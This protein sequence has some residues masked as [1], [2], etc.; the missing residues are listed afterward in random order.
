MLNN[1]I[2]KSMKNRIFVFCVCIIGW[3]ILQSQPISLGLKSIENKFIEKKVIQRSFT[4][5]SKITDV[6]NEKAI[7]GISISG[8]VHF[9]DKSGFVKVVLVSKDSIEYLIFDGFKNIFDSVSFNDFCQE[10]FILD[11]ITPLEI[12]IH[13]YQA[14]MY[15][16][17]INIKS[18]TYSLEKN[19]LTNKRQELV[20][21][22]NKLKIE[23]LNDYNKKNN[24]LWIA[25]ETEISKI[26][27]QQKKAILGLNNNTYL[28]GF[29]Y[30]IGGIFEFPQAIE[31]FKE[32]NTIVDTLGFS[33]SVNKLETTTTFNSYISE[34]DWR[35]K[36]NA[37]NINSYYYDNDINENGWMTSIKNQGSLG[38]CWMFAACG[39]TEAILNI[40]YNQHID[41]DLA[42]Q[43]AISCCPDCWGSPWKG[44]NF[45]ASIGIVEEICFPYTQDR[46]TPCSSKQCST[47]LI[48]ISEVI[49]FDGSTE[50]KLKKMIVEYGPLSGT[51]C[52][53]GCHCMTL[54]GFGIVEEGDCIEINGVDTMTIPPGHIA[55]GKTY[56]IFK[57]QYG[58]EWGDNGYMNILIDYD[59]ITAYA[60]VSP[61]INSNISRRCVDFDGDGYYNWGIGPKPSSCPSCSL[62]DLDG[63]DSDPNYG[64]MDE[65]GNLTP[66][67]PYIYAPTIVNSNET[68]HNTVRLCGNLIVQSNAIL[69]ITGTLEMPNHSQI[70]IQNG[71]TII[72]NGGFIKNANVVVENNCSLI[73]QN[74]AILEKDFNDELIIDIGAILDFKHGEI[75]TNY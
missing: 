13:I 6:F 35:T 73:L 38:S 54:V 62:D 15:I 22:A 19:V 30:Y 31:Y 70:Q 74:N 12:N 21:Q 65:Y 9:I 32:S 68:W 52:P 69:I 4:G 75:K 48:S 26:S 7:Y 25:G 46:Y 16:D 17:T 28:Y 1:I 44:L 51:I 37:N 11:S 41:I 34:F 5:K 58:M 8:N 42:E 63:N 64:P 56:W 40:Y 50:D 43:D 45:I 39:V 60:A 33:S 71:G 72:V 14:I 36:H 24:L 67:T 66:I 20:S 47:D 61:I 27:Y 18:Y 29:E 59:D 57:N 55:I 10:T 49:K 23:K 3:N 53:S 2:I